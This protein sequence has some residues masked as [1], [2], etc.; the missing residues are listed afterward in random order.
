MP[1]LNEEL[2]LEA[3][4]AHRNGLSLRK[5]S[6]AYGISRTPLSNRIAGQQ[7]RIESHTDFQRLS[8]TQ[9]DQLAT[10]IIG[11]EALGYAPSHVQVRMIVSRLLAKQGDTSPVD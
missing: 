4:A 5:A 11:Q 1:P 6:E 10:W 7:T 8:P 9:E 3:I 2:I